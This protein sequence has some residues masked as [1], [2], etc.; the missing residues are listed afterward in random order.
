ML[1]IMNPHKYIIVVLTTW[2]ALALFSPYAAAED[3][4]T[5]PLSDMPVPAAIL[6]HDKPIDPM[7]FAAQFSMESELE[8]I[9]LNAC[10]STQITAL[11][12][13]ENEDGTRAV[14]YKYNDDEFAGVPYP[15][16]AY[17]A[18][19][20]PSH[21]DSPD[22]G[23]L[24]TWSG[25]GTGQFSTLY[26]MRREGDFLYVLKIYAGGDRCNGGIGSA[27]MD[28]Q[29]RMSYGINITPY[30]MLV[31]GG[32]PN[33]TILNTVEPFDD[34]D[35]CAACC[36]GE[37]HF[38]EDIFEK[39]TL[40]PELPERL[41]DKYDQGQDPAPEQE[42]QACFD[43]LVALQFEGSST[44]Y[45]T[46]DWESFIGEIEHTCLGRMEGETEIE[47]EEETSTGMPL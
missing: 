43:N 35:A 9:D 14:T 12:Y 47:Y 2:L 3:A 23:I 19:P 10:D 27:E 44:E 39:I 11:E 29:G 42:I 32:D 6:H 26:K 46:A 37:A 4:V 5:P 34:L 38:R 13:W 33:R 30:D 7:C 8:M 17:R 28:E 41:A 45:D 40:N 1:R 22:I 25:G 20:D 16:M 36:Y 31:L 15:Y 24:T 21:P 18:I